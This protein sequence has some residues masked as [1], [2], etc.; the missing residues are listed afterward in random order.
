MPTMS[1][2]AL[3]HQMR[4]RYAV[5]KFDATRPI[6]DDTWHAL[7]ESLVLT[8]SSFGL[9][10]WRFYVVT[11]P[12]LKA[13][14][15]ALSWNQSQVRDASHVV[16]FA[17]RSPFTGEDIDRFIARTAEIRQTT[18]E[19]LAGFRRVIVAGL[20]QIEQ[21]QRLEEWC[22]DQAYL[23]LGNFMTA[24]AVLGV[25]ACPMEGIQPERY[26][27][28]LGIRAQGY[29]TIVVAAA[30]YRATDDKYASVP[31]VRFAKSDVVV[32]L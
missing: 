29:R 16:V 23:A 17:V 8:P 18:V 13:E 24:A 6:P 11:S 15:P 20:Q 26:D 5:K 9:Q 10:P 19:T 32:R 14:L 21:A 12:E 2:D 25:D 4:W 7:E 28:L 1:P 27:E 31:K 22:A 30:G 3:I